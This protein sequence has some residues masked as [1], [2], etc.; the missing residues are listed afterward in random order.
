MSVD[1][2]VK[3]LLAIIATALVYLCVVLTPLPAVQAQTVFGTRTPGE[4]T[5]PAEVVVVGF[6]LP[7]QAP[8]PVQVMNRVTVSG[9]ARALQ[10]VVLAGWETDAA[11]GDGY[12]RFNDPARGLPV[13]T[14]APA[15]R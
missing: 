5:G 8:L 1:A 6:R 2:T 10:R 3:G 14:V 7:N 15:R 4:P 13:T 11:T 12:A 9:D